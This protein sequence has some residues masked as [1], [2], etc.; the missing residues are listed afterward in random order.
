MYSKGQ[1]FEIRVLCRAIN[2]NRNKSIQRSVTAE[3]YLQPYVPEP[4]IIN[5]VD[6][7]SIDFVPRLSCC[8]E[9]SDFKHISLT[10]YVS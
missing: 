2:P 3:T 7:L 9:N 4:E 5:A 8:L 1:V 10:P 6:G